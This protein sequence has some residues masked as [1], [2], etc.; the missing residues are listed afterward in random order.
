M[1]REQRAFAKTWRDW[2]LQRQEATTAL[3]AGVN[4]PVAFGQ[5]YPHPMRVTEQ[6][7]KLKSQHLSIF[8]DEWSAWLG[9]P[10]TDHL[11]LGEAARYRGGIDEVVRLANAGRPEWRISGRAWDNLRDSAAERIVLVD[12]AG[13]VVGYG[14]SGFAPKEGGLGRSGW[15]GHFS[16][17]R[18]VA[19]TAYA[20]VDQQREACPLAGWS[21]SP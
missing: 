9:T 7:A 17:E 5:V 11:R 18:A 4:D 10:V 2:S 16:A 6:A 8:A 12:A 19:I 3:L 14:L 1:A 20:L 15:R 13:R 21:A